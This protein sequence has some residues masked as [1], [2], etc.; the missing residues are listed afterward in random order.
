MSGV[1]SFQQLHPPATQPHLRYVTVVLEEP[2][3]AGK[4]QKGSVGRLWPLTIVAN[5]VCL[6]L[7]IRIFFWYYDNL[8]YYSSQLIV[9]ILC[10]PGLEWTVTGHLMYCHSCHIIFYFDIYL[11]PESDCLMDNFRVLINHLAVDS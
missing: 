3:H 9:L 6:C 11:Y 10:I 4:K 2:A 8:K 1:T 7:F 5:L